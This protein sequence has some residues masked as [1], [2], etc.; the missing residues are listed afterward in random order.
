MA[1][2]FRHKDTKQIEFLKNI[3]SR[4]A[5]LSQTSLTT[6]ALSH[7]KDPGSILSKNLFIKPALRAKMN[8]NVPE[9]VIVY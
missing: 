5:P 9:N 8:G 1:S 6:K 2:P 7:K 3:L 4:L